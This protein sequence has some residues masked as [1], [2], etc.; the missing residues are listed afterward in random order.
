MEPDAPLDKAAFQPRTR[1]TVTIKD[2]RGPSRP[3][4]FYVF[5]CL[6]RFM[7]VRSA[8]DGRLCKLEYGAIVRVVSAPTVPEKHRYHVPAALLE[9]RVWKGRSAMDHYSSAPQSGN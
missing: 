2:G 7:V 9:A 8:A 4:G 5:R 3:A 1:Y 6:D